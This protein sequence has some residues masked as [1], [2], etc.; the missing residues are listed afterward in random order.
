MTLYALAENATVILALCWL[1]SYTA[2]R[3]GQSHHLCAKYMAGLWFGGACIVGM[4][5]PLSTPAGIIFDARTVVLSMGALFGGPIV[6]GIAGALA[7]GYRLWIGGSGVWVG[8]L[9]V[10]L[11]I[12]LGLVYRYLHHRGQLAIDLRSLLLFG[13]LLHA[14]VLATLL[15]LPAPFVTPTLD[16]VAFP[17]LLVM[18]TAV[19]LL[20]LLLADL[21]NRAQIEHAMHLSEAR[22]RAI[23]L[24]IPDTLMVLDEDGRYLEVIANDAVP[25][26]GTDPALVG[27][28]IDD[29][30][31]ASQAQ[32]FRELILS[33][34]ASDSPGLLEYSVQTASGLN[35]FEVRAQRLVLAQPYKPAVVCLSRDI[36]ERANAEQER[37]IASIAFESQQGMIIAD[38]ENRILRVNQAFS[39]ISGYSAAE[40]IGQDTRLLASGR[41]T[42]DF[43]QAMWRSIEQ[44]GAWQG[45]IWNRRKSG[46]VYPEWLSITTVLDAHGKVTH[47]VAAFT[48]ITE[49]K[50]AEERIH[51]LAFYDPLSGL[52]NRRLLLDRLKQALAAT[53]RSQQYGAL[54]FIDLDNFKN[55]NDLH[56]H[57]AGDQLL[58]QVAERL[59]TEVRAIDTIARLG[60]DEFVVMLEDLDVRAEYAAA[61]AEQIGEKLLS[62]LSEPYR[63][64]SLLLHSSAS[65]GVVLLNADE[66]DADELMKRADMSLYEAKQA[67][68]NALRFFD[69]RMQ[70]AVQERLRLEEE[71]RRGLET[72]EFVIH[73]QAQIERHRGIV[74]AEVLV[75]W[76]HPQRGLLAPCHFI[77]P[78]E[79]AGLIEML[80]FIV[81]TQACEQLA[82]WAQQPRRGELTLAVNLSAS[83]LYQTD[84][85]HRLL[86]LLKRTGADPKLLKL[87]ITESLLLDDMEE[88]VVRMNILKQHGI[89]FSI[90]DFGT[91]YSSMAYLQRLPL[92][93]LKIDQS[94]V[95]QL[96]E[97]TSSQTIVRATC[98]LAAGLNLEVIAEGVETE[99]QRSL[100]IANGCERFQGYLF[101]RPVPLAEFEAL[102]L[103]VVA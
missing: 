44:T 102:V 80:D 101:S 36:S 23:T 84:F 1:L 74:G 94:F 78:A 64:E 8:L 55:V 24:A 9:N 33:T 26:H 50:E 58:C 21:L 29:V 31:P 47:Y 12:S 22:L 66:G 39:D 92:D 72:G 20:G 15:L 91:G 52:P 32:P 65:I 7:G 85:A 59:G 25:F 5:M 87:E 27:K 93:Q 18:P 2:R 19:V 63:L 17:M 100:L 60:G 38:A 41:H 82:A 62:A 57:Q 46:E 95:R 61:Q 16:Q 89:R 37:R 98:A 68:R 51:H 43:Y 90:D 81:L 77:G 103:E 49:R 53:A 40:A 13:L 73:F 88:A 11:P 70:Q 69:P 28:T 76:Q 54:M 14:C 10:L 34:L 86:E 75:R 35:V 99:A 96:A 6:A 4:L 83:L 56:G 71:I 45:E 79:R 48:D 67:G 97:N 3:W 30:L 42:P